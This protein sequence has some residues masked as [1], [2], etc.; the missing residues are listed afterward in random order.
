VAK[1]AQQ[2]WNMHVEAITN[3]I[4][5]MNDDDTQLE[6]IAT[7][8]RDNLGELTPWHVTRFYPYYQM[9]HLPPTPV[10]T[11]EHA[12]NIGKRVGLR[13][14]YVGNLPGHN[15]ES[16]VCYSCGKTVVR[17]VGY[18]TEVIGLDGSKCRFCGTELNM[19]T[20]S[21]KGGDL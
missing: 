20:K 10:A 17:R 2:K 19:R 6:G 16:T 1:R 9:S 14:V 11:L 18:H 15:A 5:T 13:F 3:V 4:P 21:A 8:L 12:Y 7:W